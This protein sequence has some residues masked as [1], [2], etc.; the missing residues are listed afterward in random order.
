M[1][2]ARCLNGIADR[3]RSTPWSPQLLPAQVA[4]FVETPNHQENRERYDNEIENCIEEDF[5]VKR[6][7]A[8]FAAATARSKPPT[9]RVIF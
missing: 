6:G 3:N 2:P 7:R 9:G 5:V 8:D 1:R 4:W